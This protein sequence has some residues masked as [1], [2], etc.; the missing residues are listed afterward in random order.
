[1]LQQ[2]FGIYPCYAN[3][4]V[5]AEGVPV[6]CEVDVHG[7]VTA[8]LL[9]AAALNETPPFFADLTI[10]HPDNDNAELLWHCGAFPVTL[11]DEGVSPK[12]G[13]H[14]IMPGAQAGVCHWRVR[15]GDVTI[16]RFDADE[17]D[18]YL[19]FGEARGTS[20]PDTVGT[21]LWVEVDDWLTWERKFIRGPYIHH[22]A[23]IHGRLAPVLHEA[24]RF[25]P[26]LA[27]DP[28]EPDAGALEDIWWRGS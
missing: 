13:E 10:R 16:A 22:V 6:I 2:R 4:L 7:A 15:P 24:C 23:A 19:G 5:T 25:I 17:G 26:G 18:Y 21:Y 28:V 8:C 1:V 14:F 27:A 9:Q 11:A 12:V 20:G 3:S